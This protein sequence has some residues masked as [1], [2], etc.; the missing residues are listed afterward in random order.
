MDEGKVWT[1]IVE[2]ASDGQDDFALATA[3]FVPIVFESK[4]VSRT[5]FEVGDRPPT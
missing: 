5:K 4:C 2:A 1:P 3:E